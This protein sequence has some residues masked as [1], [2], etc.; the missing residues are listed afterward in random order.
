[1]L[2]D[3]VLI[4]EHTRGDDGILLKNPSLE[5]LFGGSQG[6]HG[7]FGNNSANNNTNLSYCSSSLNKLKEDA[8]N[9]SQA[10]LGDYATTKT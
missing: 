10:I 7:H 6:T 2:T 1:M 8:A 5:R 9:T 3:G 4:M